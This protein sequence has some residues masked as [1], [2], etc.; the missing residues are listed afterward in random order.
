MDDVGREGVPRAQVTLD[1][2]M[3]GLGWPVPWVLDVLDW[4]ALFLGVKGR[5]RASEGGG[6][7]LRFG[8]RTPHAARRSIPAP[9]GALCGGVA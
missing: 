5:K 7:N 1:G 6:G 3:G 2:R 9:G 4:L 8:A